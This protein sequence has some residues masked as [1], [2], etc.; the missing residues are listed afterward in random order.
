MIVKKRDTSDLVSLPADGGGKHLVF[1][2]GETASPYGYYIYLPEGYEKSPVN[3]PALVFLHGIGECGNSAEDAAS[4]EL[5]LVHGPPH[6]VDVGEWDP[7]CPMIVASPQT[8]VEEWHP[9]KVDEFIRYITENYPVN[10]RRIYITGLSMG[11]DGVYSYVSGTGKKSLVAAAVP[12]CGEGDAEAAKNSVVPIWIFHGELDTEVPL[13]TAIDMA[14]GFSNAL[15]VKLTVYPG[16]EHGAWS[17]TYTSEGMG[18]ESDKYD[19][20][21]ISIY[22]WML[23]YS[24]FEE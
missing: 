1:I 21:D 12:I 23:M 10:E 18:T 15:E 7:P 22:E 9:A 13:Q 8:P 6:M 16:I 17:E 20:F 24:L 14:K 19:P 4:L 11:G 2:Q 3:Y 5:V